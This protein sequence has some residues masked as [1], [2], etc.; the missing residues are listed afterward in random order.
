MY[1]SG[2]IHIKYKGSFLTQPSLFFMGYKGKKRTL[3]LFGFGVQRNGSI[4][5]KSSQLG[6]WLWSVGGVVG[7]V[8]A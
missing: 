1:V 6:V 7:Q 2:D 3:V 4:K 5:G 8:G